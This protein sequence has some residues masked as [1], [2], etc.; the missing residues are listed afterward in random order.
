MSSASRS[1]LAGLDE[2]LFAI[3]HHTLIISLQIYQVL[4]NLGLA[5]SV[6]TVFIYTKASANFLFL[7]NFLLA[8]NAY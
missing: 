6:I 8:F 1:I 7:Y 3:L 4:L 5:T 2:L